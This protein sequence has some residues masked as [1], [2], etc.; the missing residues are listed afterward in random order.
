MSDSPFLLFL[1]CAGGI[2]LAKQWREDFQ[3]HQKGIKIYGALPGATPCSNRA[4]MIA[5]TGV[6]VLLA[7]ETWGEILLGLDDEQSEITVLFG[8]Y[9]LVAAFIEE[10]IFRGYLVVE[11]RGKTARWLGVV[12][13]SLIFAAIHPFLWEWEDGTWTWTLDAKGWFSTAAIFLGSL[14]FYFVRFMSANP[15][16]SLIPCI[17]AHAV[18]NL[19]VFVIKSTQGFVTGLW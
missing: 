4:I 15:H 3:A 19:G 18:K 14:W 13:A 2:Y 5:V 1:L 7:A 6:L 8:I 12:A 10:V 9:T 16:H 17:A 11:G